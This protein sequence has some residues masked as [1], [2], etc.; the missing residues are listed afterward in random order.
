MERR[1]H[2]IATVI[3][4][5]IGVHHWHATGGDRGG[6]LSTDRRLSFVIAP[7]HHRSLPKAPCTILGHRCAVWKKTIPG[8]RENISALRWLIGPIY[9]AATM[10][11][12][13]PAQKGSA[14]PLQR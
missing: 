9:A 6:V 11:T 12:Y 5:Q 10:I 7:Q 2:Y 4:K 3:K 8:C 14:L 1:H 13:D